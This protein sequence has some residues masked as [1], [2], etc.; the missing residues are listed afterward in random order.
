VI[1]MTGLLL[2]TDL[3]DEQRE[4]AET[5][6][7]SAEAL[8]AIIN[9]ILDFSKIEAGKFDLETTDF[10]LANAVEDSVEL[11][12]KQAHQK[13]LELTCLVDED[14]PAVVGGDPTRIRQVLVNLVGNAVKFTEHGEVAVRV[15]GGDVRNGRVVARC[16]VRDTGI[17]ISA[18]AVNR[19][20][21]P[22]SQAD[23]STT[24]QY[25][26]TGLGL[27]ICKRLIE[28]MG[29]EIGVESTPGV[30]STFWFT[31]PLEARP[32]AA[33][34]PSTAAL[35]GVRVLVIDDHATNRALLRAHLRRWELEVEEAPNG[36][37]ALARLRDAAVAN[38]PIGLV[39][40][41]YFMPRMDGVAFATR[42]RAD[43]AFAS[44]PIVMLTSYADRTR[45]AE[46]RAAGIRRVLTKPVRRA[47]L[48]DTVVAAMRPE[49]EPGQAPASKA[50]PAAAAKPTLHA[51]ILVAED[52]PVNQQLARAM[53][54]RLGYQTDVAGNGQEAVESVMQVPYD[55]VLMDCQ[56]PVMDGFEATK[57]IR[58][59]EGT[60]R[61]THIVAVTAN[62]MEGDRDRC[63]EAGMDDYLAKPFRAGDLRRVL[64][65]WL[66]GEP[67]ADDEARAAGGG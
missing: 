31:V 40:V 48:L 34:A 27:A 51:R 61:H 15:S 6:R 11:L 29:G 26:G 38:K 41:D 64:G 10:D 25:G 52:N 2:D 37:R 24:R 5:V 18:G 67:E 53:L 39:I 62:A 8:L 55:L 17:G 63:L 14:L 9:D 45:N 28:L 32:D 42:M 30:G 1:G 16:I 35:Q 22:F 58:E 46:A 21:R 49:P 7:S 54:L 36:E 23:G 33:I 43:S 50:S 60:S 12:A 4:F 20:F 56:M 19:L 57:L 66:P 44:I 65:R 47:Q 3:T 59:R 13:G